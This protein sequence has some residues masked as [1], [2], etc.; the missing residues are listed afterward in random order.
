[1]IFDKINFNSILENLEA[2]NFEYPFSDQNWQIISNMTP[3]QFKAYYLPFQQ[4]NINKLV[5]L[6]VKKADEVSR[7][8]PQLALKILNEI[9]VFTFLPK[10]SIIFENKIRKYDAII[11]SNLLLGKNKSLQSNLSKQRIQWSKK[12]KDIQDFS[13][14]C[15]S[16]IN[17]LNLES[18]FALEELVLNLIVDLKIPELNK[19]SLLLFEIKD[20]IAISIYNIAVLFIKKDII[21][22][23]QILEIILKIKIS[24]SLKI[25]IRGFL[26]DVKKIYSEQRNFYNDFY[27]LY[28]FHPNISKKERK[29]K[30]KIYFEWLNFM[31]KREHFFADKSFNFD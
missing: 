2:N 30:L 1:M 19:S 9:K 29:E 27:N 21:F 14:H 3:N 8:D 22:A 7:E 13:I 20:E 17:E 25:K 4:A 18:L 26:Y 12:N 6:V 11:V 5:S 31:Q 24:N 28:R 10:I 23:I 16:V 15:E